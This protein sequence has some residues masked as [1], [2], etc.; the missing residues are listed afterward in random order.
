MHRLIM[1]FMAG[2]LFFVSPLRQIGFCEDSMST[3]IDDIKKIEFDRIKCNKLSDNYFGY[4]KG[5]IPILISAP[6]GARHYRTLQH[7]W[8]AEDAY[9]SSIAVELGR[10]TGAYVIYL[11]NKAG[12]DPNND[13]QT[14]YKNFLRKLVEDNGI[15][16]LVDLHGA[17]WDQPFKVDVG[18][19]TDDP[20]TCSCPTYRT[21]IQRAFLGFD[22]HIFNK[23]FRAEGCATITNFAR[24]DL[25]IEAAQVEINARYRIIQSKSDPSIKA[26]EEDV[27]DLFERLR[28]VILDIN[29]TM[30]QGS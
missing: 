8:K 28:R 29:A 21:I 15:K 4:V 1:V 14:G 5:T 2:F 13:V 22:D 24:N 26:N 3:V 25:G 9:T 19:L 27:L 7:R 18:T 16:F 10:R 12:E 17:G 30:A 6:H 11:K 20:G 23:R